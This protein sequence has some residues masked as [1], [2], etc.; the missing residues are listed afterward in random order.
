MTGVKRRQSQTEVSSP[1]VSTG[2]HG[3]AGR[4]ATTRPGVKPWC[5]EEDASFQ[6]QEPGF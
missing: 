6:E 1:S 5:P 4:C 3:F 2:V